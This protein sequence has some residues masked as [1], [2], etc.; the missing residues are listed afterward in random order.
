MPPPTPSQPYPPF[1]LEIDD[2]FIF[3]DRILPQPAGKLS[4]IAGFNFGAK[5]YMSL[6]PVEM[7]EIWN[8]V[9]PNDWGRQKRILE[10]SLRTVKG[11]LHNLPTELHL[12]PSLQPGQFESIQQPFFAPM[13]E[14][15]A[16]QSNGHE[17]GYQQGYDPRRNMQLEVQKANI[18]VSQL[19][20]R[21]YIIEKYSNF[22][23]ARA[24]AQ[25]EQQATI[26]VGFVGGEIDTNVGGGIPT[27][28]FDEMEKIITQG[29]ES[30][31]QDLLNVLSSISQE[32]MEPNGGSF[33]RLPLFK[34]LPSLT[35]E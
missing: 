35:S 9:D 23:T 6:S 26:S 33:V 12:R 14:Y 32:N 15:P 31:V 29:R 1:P 34:P 10:D 11:I 25:A 22:L 3:V 27:S 28:T 2:E 30:I 18:Y 24:R 4:M 13:A 16:M 17:L 5:T 8:S 21:S 7:M 20:S 19:G